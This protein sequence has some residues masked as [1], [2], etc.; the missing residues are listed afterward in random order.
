MLKVLSID[1]G[2]ERLGVAVIEKVDAGSKE[3]LV[4]SACVK[5]PATLPFQDRLVGLGL[6]VERLIKK[7]KPNVMAIEKLYFTNNQKTAMGVAQV[8]G[9]LVYIA[10]S[11]GLEVYE[12]TPLQIKSACAGSGR[13]DK[14]QMMTMLPHLIQIDKDIKHDDEYDAIAVGL[15]HIAHNQQG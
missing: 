8:I 1:P 11:K 5:T 13:A 7:Y 12:Y 15:T 6:E 2:Y 9:A 14:K 10:K 4:Y 3:A